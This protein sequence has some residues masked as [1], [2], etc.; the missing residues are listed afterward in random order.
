MAGERTGDVKDETL[1]KTNTEKKAGS[2]ES[3]IADPSVANAQSKIQEEDA[4][5]SGDYR[6]LKSALKKP[7][8]KPKQT[9]NI[10][11]NYF[12]TMRGFRPA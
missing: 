7:T 12:M 6:S 1:V 11:H 9:Q 8:K 4:L 10:H 2:K 3:L 5:I